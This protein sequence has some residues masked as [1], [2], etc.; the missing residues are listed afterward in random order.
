[1]AIT[2]AEHLTRQLDLIPMAALKYPVTVIGCGA[3]GSF[4][5]LALAKMGVENITVYDFDEVSIENMN[6][7]FFR[8]KDIGSNKATALAALV[9]DFTGVK[10]NAIPSKYETGDLEG[11]VVV[12]VDS[13]DVRAQIFEQVITQP[14]VR[15][16]VDPRMSAEMY[17]QYVCRTQVEISKKFYE[18]YLYPDSEAIAER[19]TAK[20]TIYTA[21]LAAGYVAKTVKD[22]I[23]KGSVQSMVAWDIKNST[24]MAKSVHLGAS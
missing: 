9:E 5:T 6:N 19:C 10:I 17:A 14:N 20:S 1:M 11:I 7:Q 12:A 8:F 23:T 3:I 16:L 4:A 2:S 24:H 13:M 21:T 15:W 18:G 22:I